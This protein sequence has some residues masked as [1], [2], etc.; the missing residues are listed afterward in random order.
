VDIPL[1]V[2][3]NCAKLYLL[4]PHQRVSEKEEISES[5]ELP[6]SSNAAKLTSVLNHPRTKTM[7][8]KQRGHG[9]KKA[10]S[11][12]FHHFGTCCSCG[13]CTLSPNPSKRR[14][15]VL[16][17]GLILVYFILQKLGPATTL[18]HQ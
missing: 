5:N 15:I 10:D 8:H 1:T 17:W 2:A 4:C 7:V 12:W 3:T 6:N 11:A 18:K 16:T 14:G 9:A 13:V